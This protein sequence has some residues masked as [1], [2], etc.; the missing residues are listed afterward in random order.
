LVGH[1]PIT[2]HILFEFVLVYLTFP[3]GVLNINLLFYTPKF[4]KSTIYKK[5]SRFLYSFS[6]SYAQVVG[7]FILV[8]GDDTS[9]DGTG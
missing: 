2:K 8:Y 4:E 1:I 5:K 6:I 7:V 9:H 3:C